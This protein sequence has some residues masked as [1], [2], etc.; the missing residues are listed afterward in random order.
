MVGILLWLERYSTMVAV[1]A[2]NYP[3]RIGEFM[4][5]QRT[6]IKASR[7]LEGTGWV[8]YDRCYC[9]R[10]AAAKSL[11]WASIQYSANYN[12]AFTGHAQI[13]PWC[14]VSLSDSHTESKCPDR[15]LLTPGPSH[16][17]LSSNTGWAPSGSVGQSRYVH[18]HV[19]P[20]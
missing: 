8:V 19:D 16:G 13:I 15:Q 14:Q 7:N 10:A 11:N 5:Y 3:H 1:L 17:G 2:T 18:V 20:W 6:T 9:C 12:E 4:A